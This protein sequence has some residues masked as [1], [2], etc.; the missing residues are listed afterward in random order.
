MSM[1]PT[2]PITGVEA[3]V[4]QQDLARLTPQERLQYYAR[5]CE[6][7]GINPL[8]KPF[9]YIQL[10]GRLVLYATR[11]AADQLRARH[12]ISLEITAR[13]FL[14][15]ADIYLVTCRGRDAQ[16]R[17]DESIGAVS[18]KGLHGDALANALM[19][20]ETKAKRRVTLSLAGLGWIDET[21]TE[22]IPGAV[23]V[24]VDP[25]TGEIPMA[26]APAPAPAPEKKAP[27]RRSP[28]REKPVQPSLTD[29][30]DELPLE[31]AP[32]PARFESLEDLTEWL[33][34]AASSGEIDARRIGVALGELGFTAGTFMG[35]VREAW[36]SDPDVYA[37]PETW[38]NLAE[39]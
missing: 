16:G 7:L 26:S 28:R 35:R 4:I 25:V 8:T 31:P 17:T 21:E 6:S 32:S 11:S 39:K 3:A 24:D 15:D 10:N 27:E 29:T 37:L 5:V 14:P 34:N 23:R 9:E 13:E 36:E 2:N 18:I 1:I 22:T 19:K 30:S 33:R 20:A 38:R 12:G